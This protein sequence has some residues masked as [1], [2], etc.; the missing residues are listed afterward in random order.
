MNLPQ[1]WTI[2]N[3][4]SFCSIRTGKYDA[5]HAVE[6]GKYRFYTCSTTYSFCNTKSFNGECVIIPGNGDIG[7]V[8]YYDGEFE[9]YQRTYV[10][11]K[12]K[13][14]PRYLYYHLIWN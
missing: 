10:L 14:F 8:Y 2:N 3:L 12:I 1:G 11:E 5:N 4:T 6:N 9:A 13:I 7:Q